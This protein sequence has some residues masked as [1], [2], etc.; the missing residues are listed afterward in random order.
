MEN[1]PIYIVDLPIKTGDCP[2]QTVSHYQVGEVLGLLMSTAEICGDSPLKF[3]V[4][5]TESQ[6]AGVA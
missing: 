5:F 1:G 4:I 2:S 6:L 3:S